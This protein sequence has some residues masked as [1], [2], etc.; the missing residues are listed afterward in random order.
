MRYR[1]SRGSRR[2]SG[3]RLGTVIQS[4][5]QI[6]QEAPA[7]LAA[8]VQ[9]NFNI[10]KGVADYTGPDANNFEVPV[11][12]VIK[13]INIQLA[14]QNLVNI[15]AFYWVSVQ[16]VRSGQSVID[17]RTAG[18]DP[19]RNQVF[20]QIFGCVGLNQ[21]VNLKFQFKIPGKFQRVRDG[22]FW[23]VTLEC[24]Q[25]STQAGQFIYKFYR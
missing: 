15:A 4:I 8:G 2:G 1:S 12:C 25:V 18:G 3:T 7:G 13:S 22:D 11:G 5:K 24:D 19:Q 6:K 20:K 10:V 17:P 14:F 16:H 9:N 21:N 23:T